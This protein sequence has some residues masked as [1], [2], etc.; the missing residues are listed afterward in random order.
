MV[1]HV[2]GSTIPEYKVRL[3]KMGA[4]LAFINVVASGDEDGG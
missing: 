4:P 2:T 1:D 3:K